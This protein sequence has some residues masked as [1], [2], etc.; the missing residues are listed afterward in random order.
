MNKL[1]TYTQSGSLEPNALDGLLLW[2]DVSENGTLSRTGNKANHVCDK[3]EHNNLL[4]PKHKPTI[5]QG[6]YN[7]RSALKFVS[8]NQNLSSIKSL[9]TST[10]MSFSVI[11]EAIHVNHPYA[12]CIHENSVHIPTCNRTEPMILCEMLV[13]I[14]DVID[15]VQSQWLISY[16]Q[17]KWNISEA[18]VIMHSNI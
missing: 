9:P 12:L 5:L 1:L 4:I 7:G 6:K 8:P 11:D 10:I 13:F 3:S 16:L 14:L 15:S 2:L 17:K 18:N